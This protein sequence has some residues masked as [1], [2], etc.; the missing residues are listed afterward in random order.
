MAIKNLKVDFHLHTKEDPHDFISYDSYKLVDILSEKG[1]DA[2]AVT[3]HNRFT[4]SD[5]LRDYAKERGIILFRSV[6]R[7]VRKR[8]VLLINFSGELGDYRSLTDIAKAKRPNNLVIAAHP[9]FP[10]PTASGI[11]LDRHPDVFDALEYCHYYVRNINFNKW[12]VSRSYELD[13]PLIGNSDA[14]TK[15]QMG[16]TYSIVKAEKDPEAI[17]QAIKDGNVEV[18]TRPFRATQLIHISSSISYRN[19]KGRLMCLIK[20]GKYGYRGAEVEH[21]VR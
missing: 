2:I 4:Y 17:I 12:A 9:Y 21:P 8:H 7:T 18:V 10:M 16:R 14:H 6:E 11:M 13:K 5:H 20:H 1:Y 19:I 15:R 3:N